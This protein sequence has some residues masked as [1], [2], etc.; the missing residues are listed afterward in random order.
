MQLPPVLKFGG[1][2]TALERR[3][4]STSGG[5]ARGQQVWHPTPISSD[6]KHCDLEQVASF[7][8]K[9]QTSV[10]KEDL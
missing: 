3:W 10:W 1:V 2:I 4:G 5:C 9:V 8:I 7:D 6:A